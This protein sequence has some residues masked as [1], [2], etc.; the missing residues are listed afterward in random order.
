MQNHHP[1][2]EA[3]H[4]FD[5]THVVLSDSPPV[6]VLEAPCPS[7]EYY[8]RMPAVINCFAVSYKYFVKTGWSSDHNVA[9]YRDDRLVAHDISK[10]AIADL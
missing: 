5:V 8:N 6:N 1:V 2:Y 10:G 7:V 3:I 4:V 9:Y